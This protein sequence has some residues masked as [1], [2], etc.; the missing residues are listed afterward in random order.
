MNLDYCEHCWKAMT[1]HPQPMIASISNRWEEGNLLCDVVSLP[2]IIKK[3]A[4]PTAISGVESPFTLLHTNNATQLYFYKREGFQPLSSYL[5]EFDTLSVSYAMKLIKKISAVFIAVQEAGYVVGS[6]DLSDFWIYSNDLDTL[7]LRLSRP[8]Y[9]A[10]QPIQ[11]EN[12]LHGEF[13]AHEVQGNQS[14]TY[15]ADVHLIGLLTMTFLLERRQPIQNY[16][17]LRYQAHQLQNLI[18]SFPYTLHTW[19]RKSTNLKVADRFLTVNEQMDA[20]QHAMEVYN[21]RK[22]PNIEKTLFVNATSD[23]HVGDGKNLKGKEQGLT[24]ERDLNQDR[25]LILHNEEKKMTFALVA[26]GIS[27]CQY[28][29]GS[30]AAELVCDTALFLWQEKGPALNSSDEIIAFLYDLV[31]KANSRV[32]K[33]ALS[34]VPKGELVRPNELMGSTLT[35]SLL[36]ENKLYSLSVG[37]SR[38][39]LWTKKEGMQLLHTDQQVMNEKFKAGELWEDVIKNERKSSLTNYI[40]MVHNL[41]GNLEPLPPIASLK[42]VMLQEDDVIFLCSDGLTDYLVPMGHDEDPWT[43][44]ALIEAVIER[45]IEKEEEFGLSSIIDELIKKANEN[46]G[47]DNITIAMLQ[48]KRNKR[49]GE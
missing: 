12:M 28:G 24:E 7:T 18:D 35:V 19:L 22:Q 2:F 38:Q 6:F 36:F 37:D 31:G 41:I 13:Y 40:G 27:T 15:A 17:E 33:E 14:I 39:Y 5:L 3:E 45:F 23:S 9:L 8:L 46:G 29:S 30:L 42:E 11:F 20:F 16:R 49:G 43:A 32:T 26:D 48:M 34:L 4:F 10:D 47:G 1:I 44:D 21:K 25:H